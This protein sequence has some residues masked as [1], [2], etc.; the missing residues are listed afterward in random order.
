[1]NTFKKGDRV[2][3]IGGKGFDDWHG[4]EKALGQVGTIDNN[5]LAPQEYY[6]LSNNKWGINFEPEW[7]EP[8]DTDFYGDG[9]ASMAKTATEA[10]MLR[11]SDFPM[12][13]HADMDLT[14]DR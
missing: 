4:H 2:K 5:A 14:F 10:M 8:E 13:D 7:L 3:I 11:Y 9:I 6:L 12:T 1:M